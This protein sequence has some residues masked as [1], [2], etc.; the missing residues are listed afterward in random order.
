M[1]KTL[2]AR[3]VRICSP[4]ALCNELHV[5]RRTLIDNGY[6]VFFV[7]KYIHPPRNLQM[8]E[9]GP[10]RKPVFAEVPFIGDK[11]A[12]FVKRSVK[13]ILSAFPAAKLVVIFKTKRIPV[14]SPKDKVSVFD[15]HNVTYMFECACGSKYVG[16]TE[17]RLGD[18]IKEHVPAWILDG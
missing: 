12:I 6:P 3:A 9:F 4:D 13:N 11:A 18:R 14:A 15:L 17:R 16:R 10:H 5:I 2:V 8:T 1:I 7:D